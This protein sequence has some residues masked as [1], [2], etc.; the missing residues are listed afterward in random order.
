MACLSG[1]ESV[2]SA[3]V[4]LREVGARGTLRET[5]VSV[6][7]LSGRNDNRAAKRS[8]IPNLP[9]GYGFWTT[10]PLVSTLCLADSM[11]F[12]GL[13]VFDSLKCKQSD[14]MLLLKPLT[15]RNILFLFITAL[16][17]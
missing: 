2:G 11:D 9:Y 14:V 16:M 7:S 12:D 17:R 1:V 10:H 8:L 15:H 6:A 3:C 5:S 13:L 4:M